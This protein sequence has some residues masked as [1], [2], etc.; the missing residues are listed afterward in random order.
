MGLIVRT[1]LYISLL[2]PTNACFSVL[3]RFVWAVQIFISLRYFLQI[4][5]K[6]VHDWYNIIMLFLIR[7]FIIRHPDSTFDVHIP[8]P[9][10]PALSPS[11]SALLPLL[12]SLDKNHHSHWHDVFLLLQ[13]FFFQVFLGK[14]LF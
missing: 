4:G 6:L 8:Q 12:L 9:A 2:Y 10:S 13:Q 14:S 1:S 5:T 11:E 7:I 3:L